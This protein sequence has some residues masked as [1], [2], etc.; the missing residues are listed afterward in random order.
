M[1]GYC[2]SIYSC[3]TYVRQK[4]RKLITKTTLLAHGQKLG[5]NTV[6]IFLNS[7]MQHLPGEKK[8]NPELPKWQILAIL[9]HKNIQKNITFISNSHLFPMQEKKTIFAPPWLQKTKQKPC[10]LI[11]LKKIWEEKTRK[12]LSYNHTSRQ[13][14][15]SPYLL[16]IWI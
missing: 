13:I 11:Y 16:L 7:V 4:K 5:K 12:S 2:K 6:Y 3:T 8:H 15:T 9:G 14:L 1:M 10:Y